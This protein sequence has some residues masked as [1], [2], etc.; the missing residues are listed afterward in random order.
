[1]SRFEAVLNIPSPYRIHLL[2]VLDAELRA[3]GVH[4]HVHFMAKGHAER[5]A[6]WRNPQI[7][8]AHTYWPDYGPGSYHWNPGLV[9]N[10]MRS[11]P[12]DYLMTGTAWSTVTGIV[13][14]LLCPRRTGILWAEGNTKTP[15]RLDGLLGWFKRLIL[16][17]YTFAAVP[18]S[19]GAAYI[20]L[21]QQR[22]HRKLPA[23]VM[24]PNLVDETQFRPRASWPQDDVQGIRSRFQVSANE[25]LALSPARLEP[26]KG[27][28]EFIQHIPPH[29]LE[30]WK[31]LIVGE[32][33]LKE[34]IE[35]VLRVRGLF[36]RVSIVSYVPYAQMP[37]LYAAADLFILP[38]TYDPNPLSVIEALH[39]GVPLLLS[40]QVGN[41][42]E[43]LVER[44]TGW[45]F[46]PFVPAEIERACAAA[47]SS[48]SELLERY[49][50]AAKQRAEVI[51]ASTPAIRRFLDA[52]GAAAG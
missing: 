26:A 1:M 40:K 5:P 24:L 8:F 3:R 45:G 13:L 43:A 44:E 47:F 6:S 35:K 4:L 20:G 38:S 17:Q 14:S 33:S 42:P 41:F 23:A 25:R 49:G 32:G 21:H 30:R 22:T 36:D 50:H 48:P 34:E 11:G 27:F 29:S 39:S 37:L 31:W 12:C 9:L 18:G 2:R 28:L 19:E 52:I 15:G 7:P 10:L 46:S 16:R 51:W